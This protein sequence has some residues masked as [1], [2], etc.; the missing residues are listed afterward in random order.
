MENRVIGVGGWRG[1]GGGGHP[2]SPSLPW[3]VKLRRTRGRKVSGVANGKAATSRRT[4][5]EAMAR[6]T[7][8]GGA[9]RAS[10]DA[11]A[12]KRWEGRAPLYMIL[13]NEANFFGIYE[14]INSLINKYLASYLC[15]GFNWLR[16]AG[17]GFVLGVC[18]HWR[19]QDEVK[20]WGVSAVEG[21]GCSGGGSRHGRTQNALPD[22]RFGCICASLP[23]HQ[24]PWGMKL[25]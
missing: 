22:G 8:A 19:G 18:G 1:D 15:V 5:R 2:P 24:C 9:S 12:T 11:R 17:I 13:Q 16:F 6:A 3:R 20:T 14:R 4:P 10:R 21:S 25:R 7:Q 23:R